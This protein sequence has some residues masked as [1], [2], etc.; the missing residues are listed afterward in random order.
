MLSYTTTLVTYSHRCLA[1]KQ[2]VCCSE[3][4]AG[5]IY[6]LY[7]LKILRTL[8]SKKITSSGSLWLWASLGRRSRSDTF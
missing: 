5:M 8:G 6:M 2:W 1:S 3:M 7:T 4:K